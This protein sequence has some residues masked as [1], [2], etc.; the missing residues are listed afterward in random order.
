MASA[1]L[2]QPDFRALFD[3]APGLYLVLRP[4]APVFTILF[5]NK[6]YASATLT[7]PSEIAG[8]G[9]FEVFPNNPDDPHA[10]GERNVRASLERVLA[11]GE[12][13]AMPTQKYDIQRRTETATYFEARYW[14]PVNTP[15]LEG[16]V[17]RFI[18][19]CVEDVTEFA[20]LKELEADGAKISGGP[21]NRADGMEAELFLR[22][23]QLDE[24]RRPNREREEV[25]RK[26]RATEARYS[27]AFAQAPVGMVLLT[28][29]GTI[30]EVNQTYVDML[31][32]TRQEFLSRDS[33]SFTHPG[34]VELTR[35]FFSSLRLGS[36]RTGSIEKRY[37]RKGGEILWARASCTMRA[38]EM[39]SPAEV[40]AIVEDITARKRAEARYRFLAESIPQ[41]VWTA[42]PDGMLDYV[43]GQGTKYF[44]APQRA[45]I[46]DGWLRYVHPDEHA[47]STAAWKHSLATGQPYETAFRLRRQG[48]GAWRWH[49]ARAPRHT[50]A[51]RI[52]TTITPDTRTGARTD[53]VESP[54]I[55][56]NT[57][58][59]KARG[60]VRMVQVN[61]RSGC[62]FAIASG[63][64][65][66]FMSRRLLLCGIVVLMSVS[67]GAQENG[68][69]VPAAIF[70]TGPW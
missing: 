27:L 58:F 63:H 62:T 37:F 6:A 44:G 59:Y 17:V 32:Y 11:T 65:L 30:L 46:G 19:H 34:D 57:V 12:R 14:N 16:G 23:R 49:L 8:R 55:Q 38:A 26:L 9:L 13:H 64:G 68:S 45:L 2:D 43:N 5:A 53:M 51:T 10:T 35:S 40:I 31:G 7:E 22:A 39:G 33:S 50:P 61:Q 18:I 3:A 42:K 29:D 4:D 48:D 15:V 66:F 36:S 28:P 24:S 60:R 54:F 69:R 20:R 52:I 21:R 70:L 47:G 56:D 41:M 67:S 1:S 25:E